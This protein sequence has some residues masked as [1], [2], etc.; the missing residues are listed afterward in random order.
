VKWRDFYRPV[1]NGHEIVTHLL[2]QGE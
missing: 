2:Q 1:C